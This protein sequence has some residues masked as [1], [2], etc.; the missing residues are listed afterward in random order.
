MHTK[1]YSED[2]SKIIRYELEITEAIF[3]GHKPQG[4]DQFKKNRKELVRLR[5]KLNIPNHAEQKYKKTQSKCE[6]SGL[7]SVKSYENK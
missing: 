7:P 1:Q 2:L 5:K 3:H 4:D 6:Y